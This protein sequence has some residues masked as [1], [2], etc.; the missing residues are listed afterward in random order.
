MPIRGRNFS[1]RCGDKRIS[2]VEEAKTS[3]A[4]HFRNEKRIEIVT[5]KNNN[6]IHSFVHLSQSMQVTVWNSPPHRPWHRRLSDQTRNLL[7]SLLDLPGFHWDGRRGTGIGTLD[8]VIV[9]VFSHGCEW[10]R[11]WVWSRKWVERSTKTTENTQRLSQDVT[12]DTVVG[13]V[14][15]F[16]ET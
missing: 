12:V 4:T 10:K 1:A 14:A 6:Q 16:I 7:P 13:C 2:R 11:L 9:I 8:S 15:P 3:T 5:F